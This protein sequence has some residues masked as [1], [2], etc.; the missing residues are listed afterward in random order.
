MT[1][2]NEN[3]NKPVWFGNQ[4]LHD[5]YKRLLVS[6]NPSFYGPKFPGMTPWPEGMKFIYPTAGSKE[7]RF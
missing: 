5:N 2:E 7:L 1:P 4:L 3:M 6:K